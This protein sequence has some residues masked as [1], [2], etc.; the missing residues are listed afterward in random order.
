MSRSTSERKT[1]RYAKL[2]PIEIAWRDRQQYLESR[3]YMLRRRY[4]PDWQPSWKLDPSIRARDAEDSVSTH[5]LR[6]SLM[7]ATRIADGKLVLLKRIGTE[8]TELSIAQQ[9]SSPEYRSDPRNHCVPILDVIPDV[10]NPAMSYIVMPFLRYV[11]DPPF[12]SVGNILDCVDQLLEGLV[13][14]HDHGIAHRDCAY[15]NLMMDAAP[16]YPK[17]F[18]PM[19]TSSLPRQIMR[20]APLLSRNDVPIVY[21]YVDFGISTWLK[22]EDTNRHVVGSDGLDQDVPE[23]SDDVPYDP[24][25]V[26]IFVLGNFFRQHF[27]QKY[28]NVDILEPLVAQMTRREPAHRP[29]AANALQQWK[30]VRRNVWSVQRFWRPRPRGERLVIRAI[31]DV[32][33]LLY[34][35]YRFLRLFR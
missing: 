7:D 9:L 34:L 5:M 4:H 32:F 13:F 33:S 12:R 30:A 18:H 19:Y 14:L 10:D 1:D 17:G 11:D 20:P 21:Y 26:D 35:C 3:G 24:F 22:Q 31:S 23:L 16:L 6:S 8:S 29:T 15:K 28:S 25:M 2:A 27:T